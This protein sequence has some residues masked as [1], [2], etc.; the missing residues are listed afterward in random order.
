MLKKKQKN[1]KFNNWF[2]KEKI[3]NKVIFAAIFIFYVFLFVFLFLLRGQLHNVEKT[4]IVELGQEGSISSTDS[5]L[6]FE[7][8]PVITQEVIII[9]GRCSYK[10]EQ[11][12]IFNNNIALLYEDKDVYIVP[13]SLVGSDIYYDNTTFTSMVAT[14]LLP[15][16]KAQIIVL[17]NSNNYDLDIY[18]DVFIDIQGE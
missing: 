7:I 17:Y 1:I 16:G 6:V 5:E 14:D 2:L 18:T 9:N 10:N 4:Q 8:E 13:T 15:E 12:N 3:D 11:I